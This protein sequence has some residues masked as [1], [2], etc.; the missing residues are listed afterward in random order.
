[1]WIQL[2]YPFTCDVLARLASTR[3]EGV[4]GT[5]VHMTLGLSEGFENSEVGECAS[6]QRLVVRRYTLEPTLQL[7]QSAGAAITAMAALTS[8]FSR[9]HCMQPWHSYLQFLQNLVYEVAGVLAVIHG[10]RDGFP[11]NLHAD[12]CNTD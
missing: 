12:R 9:P 7:T 3:P 4:D 5:G 1:M 6:L 8:H 10:R 2:G 11:E